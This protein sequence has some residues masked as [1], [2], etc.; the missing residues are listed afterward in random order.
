[1][2]V[3]RAESALLAE[4]AKLAESPFPEAELKRAKNLVRANLLRS[5]VSTNGRAHMMGQ[6]ELM[7]GDW[8]RLLDLDD[9]YEAITA[10]E[11]Q[12]VAKQI[13]APHRRNTVELTPGDQL[14][15]DPEDVA[16]AVD[17]HLLAGGAA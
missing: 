15:S 10:E 6:M 11:V 5:L 8:R 13:F 12:R 17:A 3:A 14:E 9:R 7:L 1:M 4:L 2:E 16:P